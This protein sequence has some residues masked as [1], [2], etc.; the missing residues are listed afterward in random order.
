M[1]LGAD[2]LERLGIAVGVLLIAVGIVVLADLPAAL[3]T[4]IGVALGQTVGA[5]GSV[6][7]GAGLVLLARR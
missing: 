2:A 6:G 1:E 5:L 4:G 7:I 3:A